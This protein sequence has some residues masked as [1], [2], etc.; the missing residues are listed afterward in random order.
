MSLFHRHVEIGVGEI[1]RDEEVAAL[2][3]RRNFEVVQ[4]PE[5]FHLHEFVE[6]TQVQDRPGRSVWLRNQEQVGD[7]AAERSGRRQDVGSQERG[8]LGVHGR[9]R[10]CREA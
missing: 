9:R 5:P 6:E 1:H 4:Q 3:K 10:L 7:E 2:K 8:Y